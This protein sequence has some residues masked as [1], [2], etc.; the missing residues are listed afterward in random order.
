MNTYN[1]LHHNTLLRYHDKMREHYTNLCN[2]LFDK[3][4][5][6]QDKFT[7]KFHTEIK[8][9]LGGKFNSYRSIDTIY[10]AAE[11]FL[12]S[13]EKKLGMRDSKEIAV[14]CIADNKIMFKRKG[15][16]STYYKNFEKPYSQYTKIIKFG[17]EL[18]AEKAVRY[19]I[20]YGM[21]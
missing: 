21:L 2:Q 7:E 9:L 20:Q 3:V 10:I 6:D 8:K 19:I 17:R 18:T 16:G 11:G 15:G 13:N 14:I 12:N 5:A 1:S 4:I